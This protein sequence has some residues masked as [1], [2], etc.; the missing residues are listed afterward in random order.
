MPIFSKIDISIK[1]ESEP[2]VINKGDYIVTIT[3]KSGGV[4]SVIMNYY[5]FIDRSKT[6]FGILK[7]NHLF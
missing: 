2:L 3:D 4:E 1:F 5:R 6:Q 7:Q